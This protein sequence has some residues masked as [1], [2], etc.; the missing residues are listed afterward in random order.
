MEPKE[1]SF[2]SVMAAV[3]RQAPSLVLFSCLVNLLLLVTAIYM[4]QVYDRVLASGSL[5]TL[6]W[7]TVVALFAIAVY[8]VLEQVRRTMLGRIGAW[9]DGELTKPVVRRSM[10]ARLTGVEPP[11]GPRDIADLRHFLAGDGVLALLDVPWSPLFLLLIWW[12]HPAL[13]MVATGGATVLFCFALANDLATRRPQQQATA[14]TRAASGAAMQLIDSGETV[15]PLGMTEAVLSRWQESQ[16]EARS[17][18]LSLQERTTAIVS[19]SRALRLALY[20]LT[21]G[22][23][24]YFV[25]LGQLSAGAMVGA[26]IIMSRALAPIERSISA[27]WRLVAAR[28]AYGNLQTLL[29]SAA[30][31]AKT[32]KLPRP[33]GRFSVENASYLAPQSRTPILKTVSFRL[34]PGQTCAVL[35]PSGSG[36]STLCRLLVGALPPHL[37]HVRLDGADVFAWESEDLGQYV[38][39]LPQQVELFPGTIGDN[40]ARFGAIDSEKVVAAAR[41]AGVHELIL[42]LPN[43]YETEVGHAGGIRISQG[44]RQR[45]ALA[46]ALYG[47]PAVIVLDEPNSNLD[48][49]GDQALNVALARLKQQGRTIVIVTHRPTAL[50]TADKIL[51]LREGTV[52]RFGSR[53]EIL[54]PTAEPASPRPSVALTSAVLN[55]IEGP[56]RAGASGKVAE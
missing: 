6:L 45:I 53:D 30:E 25:L 4:L 26:S 43:G 39:Y 21:L 8:G 44:Q 3:R 16:R 51:V 13:G 28:V 24:A 27:W 22:V 42:S 55:G 46:R 2:A 17:K 20:I 47:E 49:D 12:I 5:N 9:L 15:V 11:A 7:M 40:I 50:Q 31:A 41:M 33:V 34:E 14:A 38:G 54:K 1:T 56:A 10:V 23:G 35:G 36:K 48:S 32:V 19:I 37:G 29:G 52:A 18:Q